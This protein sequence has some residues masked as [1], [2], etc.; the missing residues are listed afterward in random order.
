M[1]SIDEAKQKLQEL[2]S[3]SNFEKMVQVAAILQN[4]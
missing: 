1:N 4:L 2:E 3:K